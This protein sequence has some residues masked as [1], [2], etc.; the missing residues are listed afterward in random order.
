MNCLKMELFLFFKCPRREAIIILGSLI[1]FPSAFP[2]MK[3]LQ[4]GATSEPKS[5]ILG[6]E[7]RVRNIEIILACYL[8]LIIEVWDNFK[9]FTKKYKKNKNFI[10]SKKKKKKTIINVYC[11]VNRKWYWLLC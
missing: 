2:E 5:V 4:P 6:K 3:I 10:Q 7:I 8:L 9:F 11:Y 1:C